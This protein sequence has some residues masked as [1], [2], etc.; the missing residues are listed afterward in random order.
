MVASMT[1]VGHPIFE[2]I[3][4]EING[5]GQWIRYNIVAL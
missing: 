3:L 5:L 2:T 1:P 4:N